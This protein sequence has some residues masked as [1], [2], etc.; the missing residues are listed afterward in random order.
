MPPAPS[1]AARRK[2]P[3]RDG[4]PSRRGIRANSALHFRRSAPTAR[5]DTRANRPKSA[6]ASLVFSYWKLTADTALQGLARHIQPSRPA[7]GGHLD[8]EGEDL[9][10]ARAGGQAL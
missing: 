9:A 1:R 5:Q 7:G 6:I 3:I 2:R 8:W 4:S 10:G